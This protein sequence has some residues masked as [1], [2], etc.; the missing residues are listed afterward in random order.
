MITVREAKPDDVEHMIALAVEMHFESRYI[1]LEF[2]TDK[3]VDFLFWAMETKET[4]LCIVAEDSTGQIVGGFVGFAMEHWFSTDK[5]S[6]DYALFVSQDKRKSGAGLAAVQLIKH[7]VAWAQE[8]GVRPENIQLGATTGV[9]PEKIRTFFE[10]MNF[11][12]I[13]DLFAYRGGK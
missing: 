6:C 11:R 8:K 3:V 7:Y 1:T 9:E 5:Y 4:N 10:A 12:K 13:G 2:S